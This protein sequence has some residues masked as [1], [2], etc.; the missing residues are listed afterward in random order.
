MKKIERLEKENSC[1]RDQL[2]YLEDVIN[3]CN[4]DNQNVINELK[5]TIEAFASISIDIENSETSLTGN[6]VFVKNST[7]NEF[8]SV[9][10]KLPAQHLADIKADAVDHFIESVLKSGANYVKGQ[11]YKPFVYLDDAR[12]YANKLRGEQ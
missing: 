5:A 8:E 6:G 9:R 3:E 12:N 4:T 1:L 2:R 11:S 7:I 10:Y